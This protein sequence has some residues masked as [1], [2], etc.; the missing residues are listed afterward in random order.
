MAP[1]SKG[2][3]EES[4]RLKPVTRQ[5]FTFQANC[6]SFQTFDC[7]KHTIDPFLYDCSPVVKAHALRYTEGTVDSRPLLCLIRPSY[8]LLDSL[9]QEVCI[10]TVRREPLRQSVVSSGLKKA[11]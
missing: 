3:K 4:E 6:R 2:G 5:T 7:G 10:N 9:L 8:Y 1:P 11:C